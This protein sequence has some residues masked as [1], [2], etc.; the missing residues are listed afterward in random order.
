MYRITRQIA[1][2]AAHRLMT[3]GG[4]CRGMHGHRYNIEVICETENLYTSGEEAGMG[5]DFSFL[6]N[7]MLE[8]IDAYCDHGLI[9]A[10]DDRELLEMFC[11]EGEKSSWADVISRIASIHGYAFF[12]KARLSTK[13]YV[14]SF[15][16]TAENLAYHWFERLKPL[17]EGQSEIRLACVKV[18][19]TPNC[20]AEYWA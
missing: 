6:K 17:I 7:L 13:L 10:A 4:K 3:H 2:D 11:P 14:V 9:A 20:I 19:E 5:K 16:P 12:P 1:I 18:W 8:T 15:T